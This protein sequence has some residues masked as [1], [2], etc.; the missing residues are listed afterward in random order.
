MGIYLFHEPLIVAVGS[1]IPDMGGLLL[2][3]AFVIIGI[4]LS[5]AMTLVVRKLNLGFIMGE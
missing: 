1:K 2:T 4:S 3:I 5:I